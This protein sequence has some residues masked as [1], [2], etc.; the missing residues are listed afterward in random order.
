MRKSNIE[1][2]RAAAEQ[3]LINFNVDANII[4]LKHLC[5]PCVHKTGHNKTCCWEPVSKPWDLL[6]ENIKKAEGLHRSFASDV[7]WTQPSAGW[8]RQRARWT[9]KYAYVVFRPLQNAKQASR[10]LLRSD[11]Y[12]GRRGR[13]NPWLQRSPAAL[14][15]FPCGQA[16]PTV[17]L[18]KITATPLRSQGPLGLVTQRY[19]QYSQPGETPGRV[20]KTRI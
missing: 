8:G 18:R 13:G 17:P 9:W 7:C 5:G 1:K 12:R 16:R 14:S 11:S 2:P 20:S 6:L 3:C 10:S 19:Q 4:K 15:P